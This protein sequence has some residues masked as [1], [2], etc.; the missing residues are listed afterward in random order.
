MNS[1][2]MLELQLHEYLRTK[3]LE[4]YEDIDDETLIDTLEG[5]TNLQDK[6]A[7]VVRSQ[8]EDRVNA[9]ALKYRIQEMQERKS[10]F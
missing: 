9:E 10:R 6:V 7:A 4:T 3:V 2:L 8:Q 1:P 5:L